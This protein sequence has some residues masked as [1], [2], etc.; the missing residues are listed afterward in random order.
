MPDLDQ[1]R[2][3]S[4]SLMPPAYEEMV[5]VA[6]RRDRRVVA[7]VTTGV[8]S[9]VAAT[10]VVVMVVAGPERDG[11]RIDPAPPPKPTPSVTS[12]PPNEAASYAPDVS[13]DDL[14]RWEEIETVSNTDPDHKGAT[15]LRFEVTLQSPFTYRTSVFCSGDRN[16]WFVYYVGGD[17]A[18]G[19]GF[20]DAPLPEALPPLPTDVTPFGDSSTASKTVEVRMFV[21]GPLLKQHRACFNQK[22]P[23]ECLSVEPPLEPLVSTDV[24]FGIS[25][26]EH[27]APAVAEVAGEAVGALASIDGVDYVLSQVVQGPGDSALRL[28]LNPTGPERLVAVLEQASEAMVACGTAAGRDRKAEQRCHPNLEL[29]LGSRS[30]A[31]EGGTF[32]A[33]G[34]FPRVSFGRPIYRVPAGTTGQVELRVTEGPPENV[35]LAFL[36]FEAAE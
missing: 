4:H 30:V 34:D 27:W 21:V 5:H 12:V 32:G 31:L 29:L 9:T 35:N 33:P 8:A 7:L 23:P 16:T 13:S 17:G 24:E 11:S 22:S 2:S 15:E 10:L 28:D 6:R 26:Y 1:L 25:V 3:L 19:S 14:R 36:V 18:S 20:C